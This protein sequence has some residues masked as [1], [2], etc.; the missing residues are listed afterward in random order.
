MPKVI[1]CGISIRVKTKQSN[2]LNRQK[3]LWPV[4]E[5]SKRGNFQNNM[6]N[7]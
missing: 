6:K 4:D 3:L 7:A 1:H 5:R 2:D